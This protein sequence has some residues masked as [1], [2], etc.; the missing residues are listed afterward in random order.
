MVELRGVHWREWRDKMQDEEE[1]RRAVAVLMEEACV[2]WSLPAPTLPASAQA[3]TKADG[4]KLQLQFPEHE[5]EH[6]DDECWQVGGERF[7]FIVDSQTVQRIVCGHA[8]LKNGFYRSP[9][10]R[11]VS[12]L[13]KF[14]GSGL[15]PP[16]DAADPVQWRPRRY[17]SKADWLCNQALDTKSSFSFIEDSLGDYWLN[18]VHW[19]AFSDGACRAGGYL[20][21]AWIVYATWTVKG[22]SHRFTVAFGYE[23]IEGNFSSFI[24]DGDLGSR[25]CCGNSRSHN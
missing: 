8:A 16:T 17:S 24:H 23:I 11:I 14:I 6:E 18:D 22:K 2:A 15:L 1:W 7:V 25:A 3:T 10:R 19:R 20:S 12:Q 9:F 21:F 4:E 13:A 5:V